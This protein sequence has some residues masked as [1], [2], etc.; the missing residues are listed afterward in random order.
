MIMSHPLFL[1]F[2]VSFDALMRY[3]ADC[4]IYRAY[5]HLIAATHGSLV[6]AP[7]IVMQG[8]FY[9]VVDGCPVPWEEV[10]ALIESPHTPF[11]MDLSRVEAINRELD[12]Y[13]PLG[14]DRKGWEFDFIGTHDDERRNILRF[15]HISGVRC[16][17]VAQILI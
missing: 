10:Y 3:S 9:D 12:R 14:L 17:T 1:P 2:Q 7:L 5:D 4:K 15:T 8:R 13:D 16:A 6:V 11:M